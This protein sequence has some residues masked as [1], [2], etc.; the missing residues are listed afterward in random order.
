METKVVHIHQELVEQCLQGSAKA[1]HDLYK[2]YIKAMLNT[3]FRIV[4]DEDDAKDVVQ[5]AF[6]KAFEKLAEFQGS[7]T[8]GSWLKR[9]VVNQALNHLR[10]KA[11]VSPLE[12]IHH[13]TADEDESQDWE[14]VVGQVE[15]LKSAIKLLPE[16]YKLIFNLYMIE[17]YEH[18]EIADILGVSLST[19]K[20]QLL[21]AKQKLK[22]I[23]R[24]EGFTYGR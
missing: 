17:G 12:E 18:Q 7:A 11:P 21:R 14:E 22:E 10:R 19:S 20:S 2:L 1:A 16:G 3:A 8:F 5:E 13:E 4:G 9:I 23:M 6:I 15:R 24:K